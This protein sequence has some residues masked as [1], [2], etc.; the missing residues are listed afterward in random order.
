MPAWS[1]VAD[2]RR[3]ARYAQSIPG[4]RLDGIIVL[5][6]AETIRLRARDKYVGDTVLQQL[7]AAD[8]IVLSKVD[9]V[10]AETVHDVHAW[11]VDQVP[12]AHIVEAVAGHLPFSVILGIKTGQDVL[13]PARIP[14]TADE[15][16]PA[17]PEGHMRADH[18]DLHEQAFERV[19][20]TSHKPFDRTALTAAI[21]ALPPGVARAKRRTLPG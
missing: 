19:S 13:D 7:G 2:P 10:A 9:L 18:D 5:A 6:D 21:R 14:S 17:E 3:I 1:G 20:F 15:P 11:L 12:S 8:L 16:K 4:L